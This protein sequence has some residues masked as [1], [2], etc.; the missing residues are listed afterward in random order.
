MKKLTTLFILCFTNVMLAQTTY[1]VDNKPGAPSDFDNLQTAIDTAASGDTLLVQGSPTS[2]GEAIITKQL[3]IIG[4]GYFLGQN[5][6]TQSYQL[7]VSTDIKFNLGSDNSSISGISGTVRMTEVSNILVNYIIGRTYVI[8]SNN[9]NVSNSFLNGSSQNNGNF[10]GNYIIGNCSNIIYKGNYIGTLISFSNGANAQMIS[11][12]NNT[13]GSIGGNSIISFSEFKNNI[14]QSNVNI[15]FGYN[16]D[17]YSN[18]QNNILNAGATGGLLNGN[19]YNI[20]MSTVFIDSSDPNYTDDG[21][22]ILKAGS[23]A[24]GAGSGGIDCGMFGGGY[25][26]SGIPNIPNI[27]EFDVPDTGYTNDGG[28]PI[29]IKVKSNN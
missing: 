23:P 22:Y 18:V 3:T 6:N 9:V 14:V 5:P 19:Q 25:R 24:I 2:Y 15:Y 13:L 7:P 10:Y 4:A 29:T 20:D 21:K 1:S 16:L 11:L 17:D 8:D 28:I 27:Y 26:L 12:I